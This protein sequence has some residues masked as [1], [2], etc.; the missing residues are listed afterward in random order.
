MNVVPWKTKI[1]GNLTPFM[2]LL[3]E[4]TKFFAQIN[5]CFKV[6]FIEKLKF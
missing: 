3:V 6:F 1:R 4:S 5:L 2:P